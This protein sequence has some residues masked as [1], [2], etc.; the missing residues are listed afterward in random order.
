MAPP[1]IGLKGIGLLIAGI[2]A[3]LLL[4]R[5]G[6]IVLPQDARH[7]PRER[8]NIETAVAYYQAAINDLDFAAARRHLGDRYVEHDPAAAD[9]HAGLRAL[10]EAARRNGAEPRASIRRVLADDNYVVLHTHLTTAADPRGRA[11]VDIFRFDADGKIVEHWH[12]T[13]PIPE[14]AANGNTMF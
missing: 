13:Q 1:R 4:A 6:G 5:V 10:L 14:A 8:R 2:A 11:V 12:V 7:T 3:A 9:G